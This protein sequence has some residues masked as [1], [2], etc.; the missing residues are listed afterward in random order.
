M[1]RHADPDTSRAAAAMVSPHVSHGR[2]VVLNLLGLHG[3][4]TDFQLAD[5]SGWQQTSIGKRRGELVAL[6]LV[7]ATPERRPTPSGARAI[8]W[9]LAKK[10]QAA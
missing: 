3:S 8:V 5:Y 9:T 4:L 2:Q 7:Q 10:E 1:F 6:G